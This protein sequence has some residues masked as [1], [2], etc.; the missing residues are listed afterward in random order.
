[1]ATSHK[2]IWRHLKSEVTLLH[3]QWQTFRGLFSVSREQVQLL[4]RSAGPF[5]LVIQRTL[6]RDLYVGVT[7]LIEPLH[8]QGQENLTLERLLLDPR[9]SADLPLLALAHQKIKAAKKAGQAFRTYRNKALVHLDLTTALAGGS[10]AMPR[11]TR[12]MIEEALR[13]IADV[14]NT[15]DQHLNGHTT[16]FNDDYFASGG[17]ETLVRCLE[18]AERWKKQDREVR[19][20]QRIR[21][22]VP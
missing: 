4:N 22:Q 10:A 16:A 6:L 14:L 5:F 17:A 3:V 19:V 7:R 8:V 2:E 18:Q 12:K 15:V 21:Q 11:V 1:M 20:Q 9:V 13:A